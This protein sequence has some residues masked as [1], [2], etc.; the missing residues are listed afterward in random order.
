V[1]HRIL[2]LLTKRHP[3]TLEEIVLALQLRADVVRLELTRLKAQGYVTV[4]TVSGK[5]FVAL[6]GLGLK[7]FGGKAP[8]RPDDDPA[9][10]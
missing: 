3:I 9:F 5:T 1:P 4:E 7:G 10:M 6:T 8:P 2:T